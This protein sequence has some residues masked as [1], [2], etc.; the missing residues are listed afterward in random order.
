M[1]A[2]SKTRLG[3][4]YLQYW[5]NASNGKGHGI[6]SPF[7]FDFIRKVLNDKHEYAE[8]KKIEQ[9]RSSLLSNHKLLTIE[10]FGAGSRIHSSTQRTVSSIAKHAAKPA[11]YSKL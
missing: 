4:K 7:V 3:L 11:K 5:F 6:H 1:K 8:Y 10:D 9:L 2:F